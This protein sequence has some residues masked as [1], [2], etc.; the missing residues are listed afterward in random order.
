MNKALN[1]EN[2]FG[3]HMYTI[4]HVANQPKPNPAIYLY[5]ADQLGHQPHE[6]IAIEDSPTGIQSAKD[7][8]MY[9]IGINSSRRP[10]L[11]RAAHAIINHY[12]EIDLDTLLANT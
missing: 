11:L 2:L 4:S 8:G 5:A 1:L 3:K 12:D 10:E 7:A 6:C 9:C